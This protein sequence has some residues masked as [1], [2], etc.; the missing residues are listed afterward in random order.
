MANCLIGLGSNLGDRQQML[1]RSLRLLDEHPDVKIHHFSSMH[2]SRPV[3]GPAGQQPF[4]NAAA[5][6]ES[7]LSPEQLLALLQEIERNLGRERHE[8]WA[9]RNIDLDLL[10]FEDLVIDSPQVQIPHPR[11]AFRHFVLAPAAEIAS[12]MVHPQIGWTIERLW[13]HLLTAPAY[14]ALAGPLAVGK[15]EVSQAVCAR[16]PARLLLDIPDPQQLANLAADPT[17]HAWGAEI[18]FL[19]RRA[20]QLSVN[21]WTLRDRW[22]VSDFW[23]DQ[24]P[25]YAS[26]WLPD[27]KQREFRQLW[28]QA[29]VHV[30]APKLLVCFELPIE[31][32]AVRIERRGHLYEQSWTSD[33][34]QRWWTVLREQIFQPDV[35]PVLRVDA[36]HYDVAVTEVLAAMQAME[37]GEI[38]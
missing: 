16:C 13:N 20:M 1:Y 30:I 26:I 17:G 15:T 25:V 32:L 28:R 29:R 9:A 19:Q 27:E 5:R 24:A 3:G 36:R 21:Q 14:V 11:M 22:S 12:D 34:L 4:L 31:D 2:A 7:Q 33:R 10:L 6:V 8:R 35:G 23:F 18:E 37:T 38:E